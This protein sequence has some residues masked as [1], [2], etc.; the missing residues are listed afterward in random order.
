MADSTLSILRPGERAVIMS[1]LSSAPRVR[2]RLLE[3]G[4]TRGTMVEL[5]RV[6]PMGDPLEIQIK[7]YRL[8]LR[9]LEAEAIIVRKEN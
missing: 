8:S 2:Q 4:M 7:G 6:A 5:I 9:K 1:I 3:L